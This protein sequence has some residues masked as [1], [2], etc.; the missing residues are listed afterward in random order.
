[1]KGNDGQHSDSFES[2]RLHSHGFCI[3]FEKAWLCMVM[4]VTRGQ[5]NYKSMDESIAVVV[6]MHVGVGCAGTGT[7]VG[8]HCRHRDMTWLSWR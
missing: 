5:S 3:G 7:G 2:N 1:M 6:G 8:I 4:A